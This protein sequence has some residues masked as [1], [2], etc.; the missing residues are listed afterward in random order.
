MTL[1]DRCGLEP[2]MFNQMAVHIL[3]YS[4]RT[5]S[6]LDD[7]DILSKESILDVSALP[8]ID[9]FEYARKNILLVKHLEI[10]TFLM[11]LA[12]YCNHQ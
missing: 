8:F 1:N 12:F 5:Y 4:K 11:N 9:I 2:L 7:V 3:V 6:I 10:L